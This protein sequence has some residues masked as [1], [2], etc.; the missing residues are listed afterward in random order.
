MLVTTAFRATTAIILFTPNEYQSDIE[1]TPIFGWK[2]VFLVAVRLVR[3]QIG[4]K[5]DSIHRLTKR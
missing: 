5:F 4:H 3:V 2:N 1:L